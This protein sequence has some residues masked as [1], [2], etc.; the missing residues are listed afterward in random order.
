MSTAPTR[1]PRRRRTLARA[2]Y[3]LLASPADLRVLIWMASWA[4]A[5]PVLKRSLPLPALARLMWAR[6]RA[7]RR[8]T[9]RERRVSALARRLYRSGMVTRDDNCLERSLLI[10]RFLARLN[11]NPQLVAG[12]RKGEAGVL[13]HVWVTVDGEPVGESSDSLGGFSPVI[14][15]GAGGVPQRRVIASELSHRDER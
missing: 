5:L 15:F 9:E 8:D 14:A 11:A 12:V 3:S 2:L 7:S 4:V 13:G 1:T 6:P 10:Y